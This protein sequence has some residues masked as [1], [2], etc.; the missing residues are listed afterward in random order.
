MGSHGKPVGQFMQGMTTKDVSVTSLVVEKQVVHRQMVETMA[1]MVMMETTEMTVTT[2]MTETTVM[3]GTTGTTETTVMTGTT[4][5]TETTGTTETTETMVMMG[6]MGTTETMVTMIMINLQFPI[7]KKNS[8][9]SAL[10]LTTVTQR[11][12]ELHTRSINHWTTLR[13]IWLK[14]KPSSKP[15]V[16]FSE[17]WIIYS[18][19]FLKCE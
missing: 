12:Q 18:D 9:Q 4:V 2:G 11:N 16:S 6:T 13:R 7:Q 14:F 17:Y 10:F 19:I 3:T 8:R 15:M 1:M 5:M